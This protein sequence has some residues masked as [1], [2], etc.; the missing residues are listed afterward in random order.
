ME[1]ALHH[2]ADWS[3][4]PL[5]AWVGALA[6]AAVDGRPEAPKLAAA[7]RKAFAVGKEARSRHALAGRWPNEYALRQDQELH[8]RALLTL[9]L[10]AGDQ[11]KSMAPALHKLLRAAVGPRSSKLD[12]ARRAWFKKYGGEAINESALDFWRFHTGKLVPDP[13]YCDY[14]MCVEWLLAAREFDEACGDANLREWAKFG[15]EQ[16]RE[17]GEHHAR[18]HASRRR[19]EG[20]CDPSAR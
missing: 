7:V 20:A 4:N 16:Q 5:A 8:A 13:A 12:R 10:A 17:S 3:R 1:H 2:H 14:E 6:D 9:D 19:R 18:L 15:G 11:L